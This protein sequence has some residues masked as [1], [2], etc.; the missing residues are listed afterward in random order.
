MIT[1]IRDYFRAVIAEIDSDLT[2]HDQVFVSDNIPD[3]QLDYTYSLFIGEMA[4][5]R[6]DAAIESTTDVVLEIYKKGFNDLI[7][8]YDATYCR[9]IDIHTLAMDQSRV[10]QTDYIKSIVATSIQPSPIDS[11]D[12]SMRFTIQFTVTV[13][14]DYE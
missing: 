14:Y 5:A 13:A 1:D 9:A 3:T 2:E 8:N 12:S 11:D 7:D 10:D 4:I 6:I